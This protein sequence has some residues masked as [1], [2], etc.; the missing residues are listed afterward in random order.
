MG[1]FN[2]GNIYLK[3]EYKNHSGITNFDALFQDAMYSLGLKQLICEPTRVT[4]T[5]AN[6]RDLVVISDPQSI[7]NFGLL[8][9]FSQIDHIPTFVSIRY[10]TVC[11]K[12]M[13]KRIWNYSKM[14]IDEFIEIFRNKDWTDTLN[15]DIDEAVES[16]SEFVLGAASRCI[17]KRTISLQHM[18]KPWVNKNLKIEIRKREKCFQKARASKNGKDWDDWKEQRNLVTS[19]NRKLKANHIKNEANRLLESKY[20]PYQYHQ[21]LKRMI[22]R[23]RVSSLPPLSGANNEVYED[24]DSKA[25][26]FNDYFASQSNHI[27]PEQDVLLCDSDRDIPIMENIVITEEEVFYH[28]KALNINKS[29]GSDGIPNKIIKMIAIY[30]KEPLTKIFNKS[31]SEGKYPLAWKHAHIVGTSIQ[32]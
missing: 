6:L 11:T 9:P 22:G 32:K 10:N 5:T 23:E 1:D 4:E 7:T 12:P 18:D 2:L 26:L 3:P 24:N 29:C 27:E 28:L 15:K 30:I 19:M 8:S 16:L 14:N 31:L 21:L 17:P 13:T 20:N 25:N